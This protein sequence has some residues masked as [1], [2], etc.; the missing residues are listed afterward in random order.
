MTVFSSV[1]FFRSLFVNDNFLTRCVS[2][3]YAFDTNT[4]V[5]PSLHVA[6]SLGIASAWLKEK[7]AA[8]YVKT[9]VV[10]LV[11]LVALLIVAIVLMKRY[12]R[13]ISVMEI[14]IAKRKERF[15]VLFEKHR[16][17]YKLDKGS[18][19]TDA[20]QNLEKLHEAY[21]TLTRTE[22]AII[23]LLFM[24]CSTDSICEMLNITTNYYYQRKSAIYR[25]FGI[26][27]KDEGEAAIERIVREYLFLDE[28]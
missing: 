10:I 3:L 28:E 26:R 11:V 22:V 7:S 23:W 6:Y 4:G 18:V 14:D 8:W 12:K 25:T 15:N 13:D 19:M 9:I 1:T 27:G 20:M 5:C 17:D 24:K 16:A 2:F 21:P